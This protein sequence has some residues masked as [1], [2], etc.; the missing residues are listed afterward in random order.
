MSSHASRVVF[1]PRWMTTPEVS[2][3]R[4]RGFLSRRTPNHR[5]IRNVVVR[6][7]TPATRFQESPLWFPRMKAN[8]E[9]SG[10][11][12]R[13]RVQTGPIIR[14]GLHSSVGNSA[15]TAGTP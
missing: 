12:A 7:D 13:S 8:A 9:I 2:M 15:G 11:A 5:S 1:R 14:L 4:V 10:T 3:P 6:T